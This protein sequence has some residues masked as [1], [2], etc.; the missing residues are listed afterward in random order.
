MITY[1]KING[2]KSFHNFEMEF[3]PL[4]VI[5]GTNASGKSNLFDALMLLCSL[6]ETDNIKKAF[7]DQRGEFLELF[8]QYGEN[9][10]ATEMEFQIE[11]LLNKE[12]TDAWGNNASL[13]YTRL[14]YEL[15]IKRYTNDSGIEDIE[16]SYERLVNLKHQEDKW[17]N[18]V[19]NKFKE[20]W[21]PKVP[22]GRRTIPYIDTTME[23]GIPTVEVPQDGKTGNKRRFPLKNASRTVLSSFD[24]VDFPHVLAAKE[25]MKSWKFLQLNPEDLRK[26]TDKSN[27]EAYISQS[28]RNL[29]AALNRI[30]L[31]NEYSLGEISRKLQSF[32]P[33]FIEVKIFDDKENKQFLIKLLD[34]DGKE[35]SSRVLSEG[36]LRI[37]ALCILEQDDHHTGL[38][39]FEEPENGIHPFRIS[40]MASLLKSLT[41][42]FTDNELPLRQVI[43]NTHSPIL[44]K[45]IYK[46]ENDN[47]VSIWY[48][49][50][51]NRITDINKERLNISI[52]NILPV[53]K[54]LHYQLNIPFTESQKKMTLASVQ[55]YLETTGNLE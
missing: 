39:C 26:P 49:E 54:E 11:M 46:W 20:I 51:S 29:A 7:R 34:K 40:A 12:I 22:T 47:N 25:E 4:T 43:V 28:G 21:R 19:P 13:K 35:Y 1:I 14:H 5:A 36:T 23:N 10:Y 6:A 24:T 18:L 50:I 53:T 8:T 27:G 30:S 44:V 37:L 33:N 16:V 31:K 3:T 55:E 38:L 42:N 2:F 48:A 45:E 9:N 41:N 15:R 17:I 52:T 32:V